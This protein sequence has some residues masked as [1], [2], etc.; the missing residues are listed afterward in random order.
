MTEPAPAATT[1]DTTTDSATSSATDS[2][3]AATATGAE[4]RFDELP[5]PAE[6]LAATRDLGFSTPSDIQ[7]AAIPPL[8]DGRDITG[9]AQTGTG[10]TAAFGLPL[11]AA[12]DPEADVARGRVQALVLAPTRELAMQVADAIESFAAHL[13]G[14]RVLPVYG[15]APYMPQQRALRDGVHV[16]VGTPGR[17]MDHME[18]GSLVL[19]D[20]RFL[21]LD[22]ADEMLR[23]GF[24]EDV[25]QI[26]STAPAERQVAL[27]SATMPPAIRKVADQHLT[28]PVE[29]A[30]TRQSST[31]TSVRQTYA[32][33]PFRHKTGSL[34]R[35]LATSD[36]E[37]A[38]VFTRT[39]GAAE[40]VGSALLERGI[41]AA[42]ISGDVA[43]KDREKIVERLRSG[44][45]DVLVA[46]DVAARG[47][48]VDR[49][50]LVVNFDLPR[51]PEAY[52]HRIGR[53]G[54]AGRTGEALTFVTPQ[55][56]SL[57]RRI[58]RT[59][60]TRLDEVDIPSP[61]DVSAHKFTTLLKQVPVRRDAGRLDLYAD[62]LRTYLAENTRRA[63]AAVADATD[64]TDTVAGDATAPSTESTSTDT[65]TATDTPA[66]ATGVPDEELLQIAAAIAAMA[67]GDDGPRLRAEQEEYERERAQARSAATRRTTHEAE[68]HDRSGE[69]TGHRDRPA[70]GPRDHGR[71][72]TRYRLAVGHTHGVN[73]GGIVGALTNEGGLTGSD[74]GKIDI[75]GS[76][77]L[78]DI[79]A[80]LD[81][82]TMD[83]LGR[84]RVAGR[85]LRIQVDRG[86]PARRE[87]FDGG[88][89]FDG[90][91][92]RG[93]SR[94]DGGR[95]RG[96][97]PHRARR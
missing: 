75:F 80:P 59:I 72:G 89:G 62:M 87:R 93:F 79:S 30:V 95:D 48:D 96:Q 23:M 66:A 51:E 46:T 71:Q 58:E 1:D 76:F 53:T 77:S 4:Q 64:A 60:R 5:L 3:P 15:G 73:P 38:I 57:L 19:D 92:P 12:V 39:R 21:V 25:E 22:E 10:K 11:L 50:G 61:R 94:R 37:A 7:A 34:V 65:G 84:A 36:A 9:V 8:L 52:V 43:Q 24:A 45:L 14:V 2:T 40:D 33:V 41:S 49:I 78:V 82:P 31:V 54:R 18:R 32:V 70:R 97:R 42:T 67:V 47:L 35:V 88:D 6:L 56:R 17:V 27:F 26:F 85:A 44:A 63:G 91:R 90:D 81:E 28:D 20:V 16:V 13:P 74:V 69:R 68:R 29:I 83:R 55:E 86:A